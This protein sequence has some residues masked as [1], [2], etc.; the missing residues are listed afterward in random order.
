M[1]G[2]HHG[3]IRNCFYLQKR[4]QGSATYVDFRHL[5]NTLR[6]ELEVLD[7]MAQKHYADVRKHGGKVLQATKEKEHKKYLK[8]YKE[9]K[10]QK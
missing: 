1:I 8:M 2:Q 3:M 7:T 6:A 5:L 10:Q 9:C 4:N